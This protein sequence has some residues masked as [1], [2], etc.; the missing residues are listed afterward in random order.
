MDEHSAEE[1]R[2]S[3]LVIGLV[4]VVLAFVLVSAAVSA[5][6]IQDRRLMGCADRLASAASGVMDADAFYGLGDGVQRLV[7]DAQG[8]REAA[9]RALVALSGSSCRIGHGVRLVDVHVEG[10]EAVVWV[11]AVAELPLVP[12]WLGGVAAPRLVT[13]SSARTG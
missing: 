9:S 3:L 2:I 6:H 11:E 5:V 12:S 10:A 13:G 1:G 4:V 8:S 7:P